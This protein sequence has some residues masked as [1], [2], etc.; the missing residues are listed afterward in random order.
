[1]KNSILVLL[2]LSFCFTSCAQDILQSNVPAVVVNAFQTKFPKA[3]DV[4]WEIRN[5]LYEVDFEI[6]A[7]DGE[8]LLDKTGK[9]LRS[10]QD[11][12]TNA[13]PEAIK[14]TITR[15]FKD[16]QLDEAARIEENGSVLY[17]VELDGKITDRMLILTPEGKIQERF[18][19]N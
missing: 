4:E 3:T 1:M 17:K 11:I 19:A 7:Q 16:Y 6:D 8:V 15:D 12:F 13:L 9:I 5:N 14:Q 2:L 10:K 18:L